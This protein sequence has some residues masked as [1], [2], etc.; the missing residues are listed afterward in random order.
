[1]LEPLLGF[2]EYLY[3]QVDPLTGLLTTIGFFAFLV[4]GRRIRLRRGR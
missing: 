3:L 2:L 1:M 4:L